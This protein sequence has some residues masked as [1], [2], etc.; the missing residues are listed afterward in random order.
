MDKVVYI[1]KLTAE[2]FYMFFRELYIKFTQ[3]KMS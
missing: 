3:E 1:S 2:I